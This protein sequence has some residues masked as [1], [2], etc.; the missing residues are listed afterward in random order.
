MGYWKNRVLEL[1]ARG[2]G[3]V[4]GSVCGDHLADRALADSLKDH[5]TERACNFCERTT[6]QSGA[7]FAVSLEDL[8][9]TVIEAVR[10]HYGDADDEGVP[11]DNEDGYVGAPTYDIPEVIGDVCDGAFDDEFSDAITDAVVAAIGWDKTW[12]DAGAYSLDSLD[13]QWE[14][15]VETVK[16]SSRFVVTSGDSD[17]DN[18]LLTPK[19]LAARDGRGAT[20]PSQLASFLSSLLHYVDGS[21]NLVE[22]IEPGTTFYRGRLMPR[23][24][25]LSHSVEDLRPAPPDKAT[26]NRMSPA[27][28]PMFYGS[29]DP[30]TAIAEIAGHGP[31]PYALVGAFRTTRPL[32]VLDLTRPPALPSVFDANRHPE[33][34]IARFLKSFVSAI[35]RPI[36]AD[37]RQHVEYTPT[38][39]L[40]EYL[41]WVPKTAI[42]GIALPSAQTGAKTYVLFFKASD[43]AESIGPREVSHGVFADF[44]DPEPAFVLRTEDINVYQ[45]RRTYEGVPYEP[46]SRSR[47]RRQGDT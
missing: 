19:N 24:D 34:G 22:G 47:Y 11:W 21:L 6:G 30:Q 38:Q 35:T 26:A 37:G 28:I 32:S 3:D 41:R 14:S 33:F 25:S 5:M 8:L 29:A 7:P 20:P 13:W 15:Y 16:S 43:C 10:R 12:T 4:Q 9:T 2:F 42:D 39:V 27:G 18:I 36:I 17:R 1:E 40:T 44:R 45:V 46:W 31:E 23:P